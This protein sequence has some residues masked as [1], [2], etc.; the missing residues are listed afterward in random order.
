LIKCLKLPINAWMSRGRIPICLALLNTN[1]E[2][3]VLISLL[4]MTPYTKTN[5]ARVL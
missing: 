3:L 1:Q 5:Q 4:F 2:K